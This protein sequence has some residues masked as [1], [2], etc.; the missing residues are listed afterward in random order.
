MK[1]ELSRQSVHRFLVVVQPVKVGLA[2]LKEWDQHPR[3]NLIMVVLTRASD[4]RYPS[5]RSKNPILRFSKLHQ[6]QQI[7]FHAVRRDILLLFH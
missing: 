3:S 5:I 6:G 7:C 4:L 2:E 1:V